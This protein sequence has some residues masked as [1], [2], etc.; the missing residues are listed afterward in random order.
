M[1]AYIDQK[2]EGLRL[3]ATD[4]PNRALKVLLAGRMP[5][6]VPAA[7]G[8]AV[9]PPPD[10]LLI[11]HIIL[12]DDKLEAWT[13]DRDLAPL[14]ELRG[15]IPAYLGEIATGTMRNGPW[16]CRL[17]DL[18]QTLATPEQWAS[19]PPD[20]ENDAWRVVLA[21]KFGADA[22]LGFT[23]EPIPADMLY[24]DA[25][26]L[27]AIREI[28]IALARGVGILDMAGTMAKPSSPADV[29]EEAIDRQSVHGMIPTLRAGVAASTH[30]LLIAA[31]AEYGKAL[32]A[33][34]KSRDATLP[35][36][37][38]FARY[39]SEAITEWQKATTVYENLA[40]RRREESL[41]LYAG[42]AAQATGAATFPAPGMDGARSESGSSQCTLRATAP[43]A[44]EAPASEEALL[45]KLAA[46][47]EKVLKQP[48]GGGER[49]GAL[50]LVKDVYS[51]PGLRNTY[52]K[53]KIE[54]ELRRADVDPATVCIP[55][56]LTM[57][58]AGHTENDC[59][60]DC[61]DRDAHRA[62]PSFHRSVPG[63]KL[64]AARADAGPP[65]GSNPG[66]A[67]AKRGR[68]PQK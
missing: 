60:R 35:F 52:S 26:R 4:R 30:E 17:T 23:M 59:W 53:S 12:F 20:I 61:K 3:I 65:S 5:A 11:F 15:H 66:Q 7:G 39:P 42:A 6:V 49:I 34:K 54:D 44:G 55:W 64:S 63:L 67:G 1:R 51:R 22:N 16:S 38:A 19:A 43:V 18:A 2:R 47:M 21:T 31:W 58:C 62:D 27:L 13:V 29:I 56:L 36:P 28:L 14:Q 50:K 57:A 40:V 41:S 68:P 45:D 37:T 48:K 32:A 9:E 46:R 10:P 25:Y 24:S 33:A 8:E